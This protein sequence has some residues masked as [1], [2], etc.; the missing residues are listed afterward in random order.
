MNEPSH[1]SLVIGAS[2][3]LGRA[4][5][6]RLARRGDSIGLLAREATRLQSVVDLVRDEGSL[7]RGLSA[8]VLDSE[9]VGRA[10]RAYGDWAGGVDHLVFAAGRF[11]AIGPVDVCDPNEWRLDLETSTLGAFHCIRAVLP[12][13]KASKRPT[14]SI[15]VGPGH[16]K[17]L[18]NGSAYSSAQAALV[19][20]VETLSTE[21][22][23]FAI[24]VYAV[25]P[26]IAPTPLT[27]HIL[28]STEGRK[29]LPGFTESFAEGKEVEPE[30]VG[31]MIQWLTDRRPT[32]L[33]GRVVFA[34]VPPDLL[35]TRLKVIQREDRHRLRLS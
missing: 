5:C 4:I 19:R 9:Q 32:E 3:G 2:G 25:F 28:E 7:A 20:L 29:W 34:P 23:P 16:R 22:Q 1:R 14:L 12:Y 27:Q 6:T 11:R 13:L 17:A 24:P 10:V 21:L 31:E 26:G 8:D 15:L 33:S 30:V 18:P 35:E